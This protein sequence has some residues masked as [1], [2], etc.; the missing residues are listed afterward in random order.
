MRLIE[1]NDLVRR[2]VEEFLLSKIDQAFHTDG[3]QLLEKSF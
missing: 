3:F 2:G 1:A